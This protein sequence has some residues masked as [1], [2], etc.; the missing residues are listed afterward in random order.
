MKSILSVSRCR[1]SSSKPFVGNSVKIT[2][3][4]PSFS[5]TFPSTFPR[6]FR[7]DIDHFSIFSKTI[8]S[9]TSKNIQF[10][11]FK[12]I[13][14]FSMSSTSHNRP[15]RLRF[16]LTAEQVRDLTTEIINKHKKSLDDIVSVPSENRTFENTVRAFSDAEGEFSSSRSNCDF[17]AQV[18]ADKSLRDV[19]NEMSTKLDSSNTEVF[20]REDVFLALS[21]YQKKNK[22]K[23]E[24]L[25][26]ESK[27]L[28]EKILLDYRRSGM[29]LDKEARERIKELR[30]E[31]SEIKTQFQQ[32]LNEDTTKLHFTKEEL[33]GMKEDFIQNLEKVTEDGVEKYVLTL[34]YPDLLPLLQYCKVDETRRKMDLANSKKCM[35]L[36][37]PL[38][39]KLVLLRQEHAKILG[40]SNPAA[41]CLE[42][43]MAKE[44]FVVLNFLQDLT[45]K[46]ENGA[47]KD[48]Q[49]LLELKRAEKKELGQEFDGQLHIWDWRYYENILLEREYQVDHQK[50]SEY[51]PLEKV[52]DGLLKI[53]QNLLGLTFTKLTKEEAHVWHEDVEQFKVS[54]TSSGGL[55]GYFYLDLH[56]RDGK[57]GHAA[58]FG[59][60]QGFQLP[61]GGRQYPSAA[62]VAN[63]TKPTPSKPSLLLFSEVE[64]YFHEFGHVMHELCSKATYPRFAGTNVQRDFVEAP[65][66]ML[67]NWCYEAEVLKELSSHYQTKESLPEELRERLVRAKLVLEPFKNRRQLFFGTFDM[68]VHTSNGPVDTTKL[69][70]ELIAK[71]ALTPC[72]EG[73]NGAAAFSHIVGGYEAGYYGYMWSLVYSCDMYEKF[74]KEGVLSSTL[75]RKYRDTILSKGDTKD[76]MEILK[77]FLGRE[78]SNE[79]FLKQIGAL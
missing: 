14:T 36:N 9:K 78:P 17:Y 79:A 20:S 66:Q 26:D 38:L 49:T 57:Y 32:N 52:T 4:I 12:H 3:P 50:I 15:N 62:M 37:T 16:D 29:D 34:K 76:A 27:R 10:Q 1:L 65:S 6:N 72:Q 22:S 59:L 64:T 11:Q 39:E 53:Y 77:E 47:Q 55:V 46:L 74:K 42:D 44:P 35:D 56:P 43:K 54:D 33:D 51:F 7:Q 13:R 73:T 24:K 70:K 45:S 40:Y 30:N 75:G 19:S 18:S 68:A 63:F 23:V 8:S 60:L 25:D 58:E 41:Y 28:L 61:E 67:E 48:K 69:W 31:M 71:V 2:K 5:L 21:D